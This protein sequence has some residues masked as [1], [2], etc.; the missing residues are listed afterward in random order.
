MRRS[1][2]ERLLLV[3]AALCA[4][5]G[6]NREPGVVQTSQPKDT[7]KVAATPAPTTTPLPAGHPAVQPGA[8]M[9]GMDQAAAL[10]ELVW[11]APAAWR[12]DK[13]PR[14][15]R[16]ATFQVGEGEKAAEIVV[17]RLGGQFGDMVS[18]INRWRGQVGLEPVTD[19]ATTVPRDVKSPAGDVKVYTMDGPA[20]S[21]MVGMLKQGESTWFFKMVGDK[22]TVTQNAPAFDQFL[23]SVRTVTA[24]DK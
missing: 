19:M 8:A 2:R 24:G 20:K 3:V 6:C 12:E 13:T 16:E 10:P 23:Q 11:S 14:M 7:A 17:T 4:L 21:I 22:A 9:P 1:K 5:A 15:M 18:N